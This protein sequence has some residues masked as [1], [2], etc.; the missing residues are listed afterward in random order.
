MNSESKIK[1]FTFLILSNISLFKITA[2]TM[3]LIMYAFVYLTYKC[4]ESYQ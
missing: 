3:H 1:T 2:A 4:N